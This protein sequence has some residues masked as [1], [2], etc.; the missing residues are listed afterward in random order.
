MSDIKDLMSVNIDNLR[1]KQHEALETHTLAIL[2]Q[3]HGLLKAGK[4]DEVMKMTEESPAGD[5]YGQ[6]NTFINFTYD[7]EAQG[8]MDIGEIVARL[9]ALEKNNG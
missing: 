6:D 2:K 8:A 1:E 3:V 5:G 7:H 9:R 4:Y